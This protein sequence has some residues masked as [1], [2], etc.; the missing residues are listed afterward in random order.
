MTIKAIAPLFLLV[1]ASSLIT[2]CGSIDAMGNS[3]K[4]RF[5]RVPPKVRIIEGDSRQVYE[6]A[7]LAMVKL[8]YEVLSGGPAQGRLD[9][10]SPIG[11]GGDF[12]S[13][14]QR[15]ISIHL[16]A[17][18]DRSVAVSVLLKEIVEEDFSKV[19]NPATETPLRDSASYEVFF[20]ELARQLQAL[21][22]K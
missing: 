6:A 3:V 12:K 14:R 13:S 8:D 2:G 22:G 10:L 17:V 21:K 18:D 20:E 19:A 15:S 4:G 7:R 1:A 16:Q 9:G 11:G 5:G